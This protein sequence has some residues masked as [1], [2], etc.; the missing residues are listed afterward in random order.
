MWS[1]ALG[2]D[3]TSKKIRAG[4]DS[5]CEN[6]YGELVPLEMFDYANVKL[7]CIMRMSFDE[8]KFTGVTVSLFECFAF[9]FNI[10]APAVINLPF[11][12]WL[13]FQSF[14]Q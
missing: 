2:L 4:N 5:G 10:L 1:I 14:V 11:S 8:V 9:Q 6:L 3:I 7:G 13:L 12:A